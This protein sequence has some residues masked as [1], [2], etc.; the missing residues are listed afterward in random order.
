MSKSQIEKIE[1]IY[2]VLNPN[3]SLFKMYTHPKLAL[4]LFILLGIFS[5]L[6]ASVTD[7]NYDLVAADENYTPEYLEGYYPLDVGCTLHS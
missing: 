2:L 1:F 4:L 7:E 5:V 6:S 3:Y